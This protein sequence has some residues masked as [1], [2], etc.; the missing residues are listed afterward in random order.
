MAPFA[1]IRARPTGEL[2]SSSLCAWLLPIWLAL[3]VS[4][5]AA[6][7][8]S[9]LPRAFAAEAKFDTQAALPLFLQANALHPNDAAILQKISKQ[10]SDATG[11]T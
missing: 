11:D 10:Y 7:A 5:A 2:R 9:L 3:T 4:L 1:A 8:D 6:D